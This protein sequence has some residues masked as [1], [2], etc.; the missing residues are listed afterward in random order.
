MRRPLILTA[1]AAA[2]A[3]A[4]S[5]CGTS[6]PAK[7][8]AD[9]KSEKITLTGANG[10]KVTLDHPAAKVV[11]TE[12]NV[13]ESLVTLGVD[14]AG[15]ADVKGYKAWDTAAPLTNSPKDVGTR[16]EPSMDS[17][18]GLAPDLIVATSDLS[19]SAVKQM[20]KIAPVLQVKA[21]DSGDQVGQMFDTLDVLAKATGKEDEAKAA[22]KAYEAKLA[23]GKEALK[24][25][26]AD[27]TQ[28][29][30]ADGYAASNQV[31]VRAFTDGSLL[32]AVN[33]DLGLKNAWKVKGDKD[34][35]LATTDV[36]GLTKL[37]K[38]VQFTYIGNKKAGGSDV[39]TKDLADNKVWTSLP[40]VK[41]GDVHRLPDGTWL[42]GGPK[43]MEQYIDGVVAAL[44]KK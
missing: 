41:A 10:S 20:K 11:G 8:G 4:L 28:V 38:D 15:V 18:A 26:G 19:A 7:T 31:S 37:G 34:Y 1:T 6:E 9:A 44:T 22:K 43:S 17:I 2:A 24:D 13:V 33:E 29:A 32:G 40:F 36:E 35:G 30:T 27:G 25:A 16:G 21:A 23:E 14:P 12:W 3:L 5:A 39:F 42:F